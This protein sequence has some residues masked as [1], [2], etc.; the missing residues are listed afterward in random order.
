MGAVDALGGNKCAVLAV[1]FK[2]TERV[3]QQIC[4]SFCLKLEHCSGG[5]IWMIQK[6]VAT[7]KW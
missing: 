1:T 6:A 7:G 2:M 5:D 3:E 4:I